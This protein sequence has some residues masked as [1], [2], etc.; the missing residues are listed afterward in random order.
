MRKRIV[1]AAAMLL[2]AMTVTSCSTPE[3][4][5]DFT[6]SYEGIATG[7]VTA[8]ASVHDPSIL[9]AGDTYYIYGSHMS[10]AT[11]T[12]LLTWRFLANG[13]RADNTVFGQIYDVYDEAFA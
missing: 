9:K 11:C 4:D 8:G 10:A 7:N 5:Y 13:Y 12:D 3:P 2:T 6:V 1:C